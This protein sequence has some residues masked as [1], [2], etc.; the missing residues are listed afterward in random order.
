MSIAPIVQKVT[1]AAS[2]ERAFRAFTR[3]MGRWWAPHASIGAKPFIDVVMEPR[4]DGRWFERDEDGSEAEWGRVIAWAPPHRLLLAWQ[5]DAAFRYDPDLVTEVE[6]LFEPV[7]AGTLV[8]LTHRHLERFGPSAEA[9]AA[10]L[11]SGWPGLVQRFATFAEEE[12]AHE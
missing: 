12:T 8:T 1:V 10:K 7:P 3:N 6:L 11:G 4:V 2:P 5:I 9:T